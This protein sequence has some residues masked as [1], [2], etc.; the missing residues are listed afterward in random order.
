MKLSD[1]AE[2]VN[3]KVLL[4]GQ[5]KTG[6]TELAGKLAKHYNLIWLDAEKGYVTLTKLPKDWQDR[7]DIIHVPDSRNLPICVESWLKIVRGT[8]VTIC[9][10]HGKVDCALCKKDRKEMYTICL[11][12]ATEDDIIVWDSLTQFTFSAIANITKNQADDY[13]LQL[14]D[15]GNLKFLVERYLSQIQAATYNVICISHEEEAETEDGK[16]KIVPVC[17]SSKSSRNT[18]KYFDHVIYAEIKNK[19]HTFSSSTT[20]SN[21][22]HAGSRTGVILETPIGTKPG[23]EKPATLLDIFTSWKTRGD[24]PLKKQTVVVPFVHPEVKA[25]VGTS[26]GVGPTKPVSPG[27]TAVA[28][29]QGMGAKKT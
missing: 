24:R 25:S 11:N 15:W 13:K 8:P 19:K 20:F 22:I 5:P 18:G 3:Q 23:E 14:D 7:I 27:Q 29:L 10:E 9:A 1:I 2:S 28:N 26:V 16:K 21:S 6:K 12:N 4:Y 17:G